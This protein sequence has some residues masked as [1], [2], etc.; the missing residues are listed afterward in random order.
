MTLAGDDTHVPLDE[1]FYVQAV[2]DSMVN[3]LY[4]LEHGGAGLFSYPVCHGLRL[5]REGVLAFH[6]SS[7]LLSGVRLNVAEY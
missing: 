2:E 7:L 4:H 5:G 6:D 1:M 3:F